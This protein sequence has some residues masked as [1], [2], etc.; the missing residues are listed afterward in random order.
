[1]NHRGTAAQR[2]RCG[3]DLFWEFH[4]ISPGGSS[5]C[6]RASVV[7]CPGD[8]LPALTVS[9]RLGTPNQ[10]LRPTPGDAAG[11]ITVGDTADAGSG[12]PA[13]SRRP[14]DAL[15]TWLQ[16]S[17]DPRLLGYALWNLRRN[18]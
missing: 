5:L 17:W 7:R 8:A 11:R 4:D 10:A 1:M 9:R 18:P 15:G 16:G 13:V 3:S 6:L 14:I 2:G 12:R